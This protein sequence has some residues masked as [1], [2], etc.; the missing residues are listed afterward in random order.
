M[1]PKVIR[2][3]IQDLPKILELQYL[4]YQSEAALFGDPNIQPLTET[5]EELEAEYRRGTVLKMVTDD[6]KIIGSVRSYSAGGT[7]YIGKLMVHPDFQHKG[8]GTILIHKIEEAS[9]D[10]RYELF[11]STRS[12]NNIRLYE[13]LGYR[14]FKEEGATEKI[15]FVYLE[16]S[17]LK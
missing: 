15:V 9:D 11:T 5:L 2:A 1:A 6:G 7:T 8:F 4:A 16:K 10:S 14:K 17:A 13:K 12:L 3:D